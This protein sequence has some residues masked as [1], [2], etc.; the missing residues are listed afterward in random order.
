LVT[1]DEGH[2]TQ[3]FHTAD[4]IDCAIKLLLRVGS[5]GGKEANA[6]DVAG[7]F[8]ARIIHRGPAKAQAENAWIQLDIGFRCVDIEGKVA[9]CIVCCALCPLSDTVSRGPW[10]VWPFTALQQDHHTVERFK[11]NAA[12]CAQGAGLPEVAFLVMVTVRTN[13]L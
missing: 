5:N 10:K 6:G 8:G 1:D 4:C 7:R 2:P 12:N 9:L 13:H 11:V 3:S